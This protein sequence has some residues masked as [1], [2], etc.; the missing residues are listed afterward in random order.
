MLGAAGLLC[1]FSDGIESARDGGGSGD[2]NVGDVSSGGCETS[3]TGGVFGRSDG[4]VE[5]SSSRR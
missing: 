4:G 3:S 5:G 1:W 2:V